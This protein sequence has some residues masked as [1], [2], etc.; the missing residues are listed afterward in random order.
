MDMSL[1]KLW[2]LLMDRE[3]WHACGS[4]GHKE[5]DTS[6]WLNWTENIAI[7]L[8]LFLKKFVMTKKMR[9][10]CMCN[11][12]KLYSNPDSTADNKF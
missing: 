6:E 8:L 1:D 10:K 12:N 2:E 7:Y 11:I 4:W 9:K 5:S 3:A